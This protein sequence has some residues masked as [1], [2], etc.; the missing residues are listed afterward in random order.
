M[1]DFVIISRVVYQILYRIKS[2]M[3]CDLI[4][5]ILDLATFGIPPAHTSFRAFRQGAHSIIFAGDNKFAYE[6][7]LVELYESNRHIASSYSLKTFEKKII[8][9]I[10]VLSVENRDAKEADIEAVIHLLLAS[11]LVEFETFNEV[12]G[13]HMAVP[14]VDFGKFTIYNMALAKDEILDRYP[15]IA[16]REPAFFS[17]VRDSLLISFKATAREANK[18]YEIAD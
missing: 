15:A 9:L 6:R 12:V 18:A 16:V 10:G 8:D 13:C 4:N 17:K 2:I 7:L 1:A 3:K 11:E 5:A 14:K